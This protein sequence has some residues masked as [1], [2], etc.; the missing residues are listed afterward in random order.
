MAEL[1]DYVSEVARR[2]LTALGD[3]LVG[4]YLH[5]S[6]AMDA[7]VPTRSDV[8]VLVV[9]RAPL[10]PAVKLAVASE[11]SEA[12]LPCPGVG[13]EVSIVTLDSARSS[14]DRPAFELHMDTQENTVDHG[15][16]HPGARHPG[17]PDLI[18]HF[19]MARVRGVA[20]MGPPAEE[21]IA[22]VARTSLLRSMADDLEWGIERRMTGYAV[23]N[24]CR[25][26]RFAREGTLCSKPEGGEWAMREGLVDADLVR[27]ALRRQAGSDEEVEFDMGARFVALARE[28]LLREADA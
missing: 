20:L 17:D 24:A 27:A 16:R 2:V 13:L 11:L 22:P 7:F 28:E 9:S 18:A 8:D 15:A 25:A 26:L 23:L 12:A 1:N 6:V 5:G 3:D 19:A 21:V 4:V 10:A 14:S